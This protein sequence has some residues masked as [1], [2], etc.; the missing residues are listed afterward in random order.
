MDL[1]P[2]SKAEMLIERL[3][4]GA[5]AQVQFVKQGSSGYQVIHTMTQRDNWSITGI[6]N[7]YINISFVRFS[8]LDFDGFEDILAQSEA[9][10]FEDILYKLERKHRPIGLNRVW[11]FKLETLSEFPVEIT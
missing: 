5:D 11:T 1:T 2:I 6:E 8:V 4:L 3:E 7:L 9:I 10:Y